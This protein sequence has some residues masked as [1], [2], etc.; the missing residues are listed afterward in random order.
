MSHS[1]PLFLHF[2]LIVKVDSKQMFDK[3]LPVTGYEP[4]ISGVGDNCS[5]NW[6]TTTD[7]DVVIGQCD[8][9]VVIFF[10]S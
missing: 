2:H 6:A 7:Q 5:T 3:S 1:Q 4:R 10:I 8:T 9:Y